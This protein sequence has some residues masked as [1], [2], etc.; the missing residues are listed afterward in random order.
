MTTSAESQNCSNPGLLCFLWVGLSLSIGWGIR[1]N[2]GHEYGAMIPG[3][4][5][6]LAVALLA[7]RGDWHRRAVF[8]AFFG[9]FG[10]SFGGSMSYMQVI[11]YTHSGH[12][13]S[14]LYGFACLYVI[15][16]LWAAMGGAGAALPAF[17]N[18]ERL[19]EF[20]APLTAVFA[21]WT[22]QDI[23]TGIWFPENGDYRQVNPL[24]WYDTDWLAALVAMVA[25][26]VLALIRRRLDSASSLILHLAAGWW[27]GF[28]LLVN[29]LGW[30]MTPPRGDNWAGCVGMVTG[31][32]VYF[33][34]NKMPGLI[35]ATLVTGFI[36]GFGFATGQLFKL[37]E[38]S[39]GLQT[40]W[41][42]VL[43]QTYGLIN[44][45]GLAV[46]L[47]WVAR[48]AP[49]TSE[50]PPACVDEA[51]LRRG[52]AQF[53]RPPGKLETED[54]PAQRRPVRPLAETYA[55]FFVLLV[56]TYLNLVKNPEA[57]VKAKAMPAA[58]YGLSAVAWF[59]LAYVAVAG[60]FIGLWMVHRRRPLPVLSGNWL[61]RAQLLYLVFLWVMVAGNFERALVSFAPQRL[62]TEGVIW[63][64]A[65]LCSVGI[66]L[67]A[68]ALERE[69]SG[70][71]FSW[72]RLLPKTIFVG[73]IAMVLSVL[74]DWG[75]TRALYGDQPAPH[76]SKHIRFGPN[77]TA[78]KEKPKPGVP[79]P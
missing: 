35:F 16:F 6:S 61:G 10:W 17:L 78:T 76:A 21:G 49:A 34:R 74:A 27:I 63:F 66:F 51:A 53:N 50:G 79:H 70:V 71:G 3:M 75:V 14:Q 29:L 42:S 12:S 18:R 44:G 2:F 77:A 59:N 19:T 9:A 48:H 25:V 26:L 13:L 38:I 43:E 28:L 15:G 24:Y 40:N 32:L 11:G 55:A 23:V 57:W 1:G 39:T 7:G 33:W 73:L 31:M 65:A 8:F 69:R 68:P 5:A 52:P 60:A 56:I 22:L 37:L 67:S 54:T 20:F 72:P 46:A 45:I 58:M 4:L 62:V 30:R 41:H 64:N 36:G 47:F